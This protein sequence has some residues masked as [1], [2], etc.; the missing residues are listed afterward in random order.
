MTAWLDAVGGE[1]EARERAHE[2]AEAWDCAED[3]HLWDEEGACLQCP[4]V[5]EPRDTPHDHAGYAENE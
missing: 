4:A 5:N 3:G 2:A 1:D